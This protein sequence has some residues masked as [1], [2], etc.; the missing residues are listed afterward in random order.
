MRETH[1]ERRKKND[2][3]FHQYIEAQRQRRKDFNVKLTEV[4]TN[5]IHPQKNHD[6]LI[7]KEEVV[8]DSKYGTAAKE[9]QQQL[10]TQ[11]A[12]QLRKYSIIDEITQGAEEFAQVV[13]NSSSEEPSFV[14]DSRQLDQFATLVKSE[15][16]SQSG[17]A[18]DSHVLDLKPQCYSQDKMISEYYDV[19]EIYTD[20]KKGQDTEGG[21]DT[22]EHDPKFYSALGHSRVVS[23]EDVLASMGNFLPADSATSPG[24]ITLQDQSMSKP[25][26]R[27]EDLQK[28]ESG[29]LT[30]PTADEFKDDKSTLQLKTVSVN[31]E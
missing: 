23:T 9:N 20:H 25:V 3:A 7:V 16:P 22:S 21:A 1:Y 4:V 30:I 8:E 15:A 18:N 11:D 13:G 12:A 31:L 2:Q 10:P 14:Q 27:F 6:K 17:L 5:Q 26:V 28:D 29:M 19:G 24:K